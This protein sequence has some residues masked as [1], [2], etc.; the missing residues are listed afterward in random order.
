MVAYQRGPTQ[1]TASEWGRCDE[2]DLE[3]HRTQGILN[4]GANVFDS[5]VNLLFA[6]VDAYVLF[7]SD[8]GK[9]H[10]DER[11]LFLRSH[12]SAL[13]HMFQNGIRKTLLIGRKRNDTLLVLSDDVV[14]C[15]VVNGINTA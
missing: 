3:L 14:N 9:D 15:A 4:G 5:Q 12:G 13:C 7:R 8:G 10:D 6:K 11:T 1:P 2:Y